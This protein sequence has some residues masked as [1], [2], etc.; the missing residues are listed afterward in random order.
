MGHKK[1][2]DLS[3]DLVSNYPKTV[4]LRTVAGGFPQ[5]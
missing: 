5:F 4:D 3:L 2:K 1:P